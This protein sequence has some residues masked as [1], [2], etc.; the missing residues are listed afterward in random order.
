MKQT[1]KSSK[2]RLKVFHEVPITELT[3]QIVMKISKQRNGRR[4]YF[5][6]WHRYL[7]AGENEAITKGCKC[8]CHGDGDSVNKK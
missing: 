5:S 7:G 4:W 6:E 3:D 2:K 1:E 8:H